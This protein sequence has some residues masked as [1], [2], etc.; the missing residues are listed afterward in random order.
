MRK[1]LSSIILI[2]T[3]MLLCC[4]CAGSEEKKYNA[5]GVSVRFLSPRT[6]VV[7]MKDIDPAD[8]DKS[9]IFTVKEAKLSGSSLLVTY[10]FNNNASY[11]RTFNDVLGWGGVQTYQEG[12]R[13]EGTN[14]GDIT[15]NTSVM[16][17]ASVDIQKKYTLRNTTDPVTI[18]VQDDFL[19]FSMTTYV[20]K[21]IGFGVVIDEK[22]AESPVNSVG[23]TGATKGDGKVIVN[24]SFTNN[25]DTAVTPA[26]AVAVQAFQGEKKLD[27][28]Q[29]SMT[30]ETH[31][32]KYYYVEPDQKADLFTTFKLK[33]NEEDVTVYLTVPSSAE[34]YAKQVYKVN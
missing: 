33:N 22:Y 29:E 15:L 19:L 6:E 4:G 12:V 8:I 20:H 5:E 30:D 9:G 32:L 24:Y 17:G 34:I 1:F 13:I 7:S 16:G 26:S 23:I 2:L 10:Q 28:I 21:E 14:V 18:I 31:Y 3:A 25:Q 27:I 11:A